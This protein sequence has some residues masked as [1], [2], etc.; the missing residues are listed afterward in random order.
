MCSSSANGQYNGQ[1]AYQTF[2]T[3]IAN[4]MGQATAATLI[5]YAQLVCV[6]QGGGTAQSQVSAN[7][8]AVAQA[9]VQ[10][11][12][13]AIQTITG[14][15]GNG[16]GLGYEDFLS[17]SSAS[18]TAVATTIVLATDTFFS[19][20]SG[21]AAS[22]LAPTTLQNRFST[23]IAN[24]VVCTIA[25]AYGQ[26]Y[27]DPSYPAITAA[28]CSKSASYTGLGAAGGTAQCAVTPVCPCNNPTNLIQNPGFEAGL[29]PWTISDPAFSGVVN[30]DPHSGSLSMYLGEVGA[31]STVSQ[32]ITG[33]NPAS[34]AIYQLSF[35]MKN[36]AAPAN[37]GALII[38]D[39]SNNPIQAVNS[40]GP[41]PGSGP[42]L[43]FS[44]VGPFPYNQYV[45]TFTPGTPSATIQITFS[46]RQDPGQIFLDDFSLM[47]SQY[48]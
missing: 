47:C 48:A 33:L 16:C 40:Y 2:P 3:A 23:S 29:A 28:S 36:N 42:A 22:C 4:L 1:A 5:Q 12:A 10:A 41:Y 35:W 8:Q 43:P 14:D 45:F 30:I 44:N 26:V 38:L 21:S 37:D 19:S 15:V 24:A 25:S 9:V 6:C 27:S 46:A 31:D 7:V 18:A 13:S 34:D 20:L 17:Y 11:Y 32:V 39:G